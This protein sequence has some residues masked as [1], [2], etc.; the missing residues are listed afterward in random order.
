[1]YRCSPNICEH[2][3]CSDRTEDSSWNSEQARMKTSQDGLETHNKHPRFEELR[4]SPV[5]WEVR[6]THTVSSYPF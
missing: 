4:I 5:V 6:M 1:M 3:L 2:S